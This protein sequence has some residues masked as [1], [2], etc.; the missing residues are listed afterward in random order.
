[1]FNIKHK[2]CFSYLPFLMSSFLIISCSDGSGQNIQSVDYLP[3]CDSVTEANASVNPKDLF[4]LAV[5]DPVFVSSSLPIG[6]LEAGDNTPIN[7]EL[8]FLLNAINVDVTAPADLYVKSLTSTEYLTGSRAGEV[9]YGINYQVCSHLV[10]NK[11]RVAVEGDYAHMTGINNN[12]M[13]TLGGASCVEDINDVES[14]NKCS[15][16]YIND[17]LLIDKGTLIGTAGG[18]GLTPYK[19]GFDANLID[20]RFVNTFVNPDRIGAEEG[21]G[22]GYRYGACTYEYFFDPDK[23]AYLNKVGLPGEPRDSISDPCGKLSGVGEAGT[24]AGIWIPEDKADL[25]VSTQLFDVMSNI[26]VLADHLINPDSLMNISTDSVFVAD[27]GGEATLVDL[28]KVN[29]GDVNVAYKNMSPGTVYCLHGTSNKGGG[30]TN[31][32][33][34]LELV[35]AGETLKLERLV[36]ACKNTPEASRTFTDKVMRF[37]R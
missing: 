1:M 19:P 27:V 25:D 8:G 34:Y 33:Y 2:Q 30:T 17:Y 21:P 12:L 14:T 22:A 6:E 37:V 36:S 7:H 23:T 3:S 32:Y 13:T 10:N 15:V 18:T 31:F 5:V 26:L 9:D 29:T 4:S 35:D 24:A 11:E 20:F 16:N 28:M